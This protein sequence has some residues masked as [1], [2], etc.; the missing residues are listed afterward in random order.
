MKLLISAFL[1]LMLG[2]AGPASAKEWAFKVY[3]DGREIGQHTFTLQQHGDVRELTSQAKFNVKVLF[4]D[5]YQYTHTASEKW[6]RDCLTSLAARTVEN[7]EVTVVKG[8]REDSGFVVT[9]P[10]GMQTLPACVMTFAY[11]N[12]NM[13]TQDK[14]LNPQTGEWLDVKISALGNDTITVRGKPVTAEHYK[15]EAPKLKIELWYSPDKEWLA[16]QSTT[17]EGYVISYKLR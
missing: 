11:W 12:P 13:L 2:F 1:L 9:S 8:Q 7:K 5:A 3:L 15:L 6:Q 4:I 14:L 16:L 17:P 10:K